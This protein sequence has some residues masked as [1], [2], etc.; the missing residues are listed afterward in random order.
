MA[1]T[2]RIRASILLLLSCALGTCHVM[3]QPHFS[4]VSD[5]VQAG[6]PC[7]AECLKAGALFMQLL[8][9]YTHPASGWNFVVM[10]DDTTCQHVL[11]KPGIADGLGERYGETDIA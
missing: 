3:A 10:C 11:R 5:F 7:P 9:V 6:R 8:S 2:M 4:C 1:D